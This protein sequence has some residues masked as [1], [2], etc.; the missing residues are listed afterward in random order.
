M[1]G[2]MNLKIQ[3]VPHSFNYKDQ[4]GYYSQVKQSL[5]IWKIT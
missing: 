2:D 1:Y 5:L 4:T 3:L